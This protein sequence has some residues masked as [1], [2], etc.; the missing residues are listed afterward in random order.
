MF[1][2]AVLPSCLAMTLVPFSH[3]LS[4]PPAAPAPSPLPTQ[5]PLQIGPSS[6]TLAG[7]LSA[8][9]ASI[10]PIA[11]GPEAAAEPPARIP[12][13]GGV[14]DAG[15]SVGQTSRRRSAVVDETPCPPPPSRTDPLDKTVWP[16]CWARVRP[17]SIPPYRSS[18][19]NERDET[20]TSIWTLALNG[21][22]FRMTFRHRLPRLSTSI[23]GQ[24][25]SLHG[26]CRVGRLD[27]GFELVFR[28]EWP[29]MVAVSCR[30]G[31]LENWENG[32]INEGRFE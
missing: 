26:S 9:G 18:T 15:D 22:R 13:R 6:D 1:A 23:C 29:D 11:D 20:L 19:Q 17:S 4:P 28:L 12:R 24:D 5:S 2:E 32:P 7:D 14:A 16:V 25:A 21:S 8:N 30:L 27:S 3:P 10:V 31:K